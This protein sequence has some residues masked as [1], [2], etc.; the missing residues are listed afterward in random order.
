M[1]SLKAISIL[2]ILFMSILAFSQTNTTSMKLEPTES[3]K[4]ADRFHI[5]MAVQA[6][7]N[8]YKEDSPDRE[9]STDLEINPSVYLGNGFSLQTDTIISKEQSGPRNTTISNTKIILTKAGPKLGDWGT[10]LLMGGTAPTDENLRRDESYQGGASLGGSIKGSPLKYVELAY[11]LSGGRN[12]HGYDRTAAGDANVQY[13]ITHKLALAYEFIP[14]WSLYGIGSYKNG[15]TYQNSE[16]SSYTN[17]FG[18]G[19]QVA[20]NWEISGSISNEGK[21]FKAN[22][23]DSNIKVYDQNTTVIQAAVTFTN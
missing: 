10:A 20:K 15:W 13:T 6:S 18:L 8:L 3:E 19:Y 2:V 17:E 1:N 11:T 23:Q 22:G 5:L 21:A 14:K 7:S 16:R 9:A 12:F 4:R